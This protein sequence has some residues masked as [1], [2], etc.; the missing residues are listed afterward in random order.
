MKPVSS[1]ASQ[2]PPKPDQE[3]KSPRFAPIAD[4]AQLLRTAE[5]NTRGSR[6]SKVDGWEQWIYA[7]TLS[8]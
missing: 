5:T 1:L 2:T 6:D 4:I 3:R 8:R 7:E